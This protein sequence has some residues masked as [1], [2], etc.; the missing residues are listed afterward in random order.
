MKKNKI[1][2]CISLICFAPMIM[3]MQ[4]MDDQSLSATTGQDGI[5]I[6]VG[7]SKVQF[8]QISL[9]DTNGIANTSYGSRAGMTLAST[10]NTPV[11]LNFSG[12]N[13][14]P[15]F[16][17]VVDTDAGAN[18]K[19][20]ANLAISFANQITGLTLSP[21]SIYLVGTN[22]TS[23]ISSSK[24]IFT[25]TSLNSDI[26]ELIRVG[27]SVNVNFISGNSPKMNIQLGNAPQGH[28][29]QFGGAIGSIC[30]G[31]CPI[32]LISD[33]SG[34][35]ASFTVAL[36]ANDTTNGFLLNNFYAGIESGGFVFGNTGTSSKLDASLSTVTLGTTGQ[37]SS[38]VFNGIQN[39]P[40][41]NI[42]AVGASVTDLKVKISG[43]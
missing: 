35:G 11:T 3:A 41:G 42:G 22:S 26:K 34:A 30:S 4:P 9:I 12:A 19:A 36:K 20:F 39:G 17:I 5:N 7:M 18:N 10:T 14:S 28:M 31:G 40:I 38:T 13:N 43:M 33:N 24:S 8:N 23:S 15:T 37:S 16:N 2:G 25:G 21:F 32:T 27:S 6:G 29:I 1:L